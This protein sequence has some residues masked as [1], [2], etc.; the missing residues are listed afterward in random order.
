MTDANPAGAATTDL[1]ALVR[2]PRTEAVIEA[3]RA[4]G[5]YDPTRSVEAHGEKRVAVPVVEPPAETDVEAVAAV[6]LPLR[7]RGLE[8]LLAERGFSIAEIEAAPSS[9]AVIG[10]VILADFGDVSAGDSLSEERREAV[11]ES[12]ADT[13]P[14]SARTTLPMTA[15]DEG[16]ASIS[17]VENPRSASRSSRPRSR[18]GRSTAATGS[19]SVSTG[20]STTGTAIRS[21]SWAST[22]RVGSYTPSA[23]SASMTASVRGFS[24]RAARSVVAA[25]AGLASVIPPAGRV[26][27]CGV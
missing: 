27:R 21:S 24:T 19:T 16:A 15:H 14:K 12:P 2:K 26:A 10:S 11:G 4:E 25:P 17:A 9:W 23:R 18:S 6:E 8:D 20:G 1:A 3:L 7:E 22:L 5:V 13:S